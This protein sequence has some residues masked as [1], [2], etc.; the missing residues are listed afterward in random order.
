MSWSPIGNATNGGA[1]PTA[2]STVLASGITI[3][4]GDIVVV[5]AGGAGSSDTFASDTLADDIGNIYTQEGHAFDGVNHQ[6]NC[7]YYSIATHSGA[8]TLTATY[9]VSR[10]FRNV[11][12]SVYRASAGTVSLDASAIHATANSGSGTDGMVASA[13]TPTQDNDLA[14][15]IMGATGG[16]F[17]AW[18]AGTGYTLDSDTITNGYDMIES[19]SLGAGTSGVAQTPTATV[20][21]VV[22]YGAATFL[23]KAAVSSIAAFLV[24]G[25]TGLD[26]IQNIETYLNVNIAGWLPYTSTGLDRLANI[27]AFLTSNPVNSVTFLP[28]GKTGTDR[29]W[30]IES[31]LLSATGSSG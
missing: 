7:F 13:A 26:R 23:F 28:Y 3:A 10:A 29:L 4:V 1:N 2:A 25:H 18:A 15:A 6:G 16:S 5:C 27:E 30:N 14:V 31:Y 19:K 9:N 8:P 20:G 21:A 22:P 12:V 24:Y 11:D 17:T